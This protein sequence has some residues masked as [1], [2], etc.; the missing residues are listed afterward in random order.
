MFFNATVSIVEKIRL[1]FSKKKELAFKNLL[2]K[3]MKTLPDGTRYFS[4]NKFRIFFQPD[5]VIR[6]EKYFVEGI[7]QVLRE[8]FLLPTFFTRQVKIHKG[9]VVLDLGANIGT[10]ALVFS[11]LV[12]PGGKVYAFEPVTYNIINKNIA[13]NTVNNIEVVPEG[14]SDK[15]GKAKIEISDFCLDSS[16]C[17]REYTKDYYKD[18]KDIQLTSLDDYARER[19]LGRIDFIKMD[20]E[21]A[22]ELAIRGAKEIIKKFHPKWSISS[23]HIDFDNEPQHKKLVTLLHEY[24]YRTKEIKDSHIYAW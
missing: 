8:T 12:G 23:Y 20:I 24:G 6:D 4:I 10:T 3:R 2:L 21:G 7:T 19:N 9:D 13:E 14:V 18:T 5:Y 11:E 17:K 15:K 16:I 22:E 1:I